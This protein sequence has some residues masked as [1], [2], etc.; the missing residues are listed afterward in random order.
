MLIWTS[1]TAAVAALLWLAT[2][3]ALANIYRCTDEHGSLLFSQYPCPAA[4]VEAMVIQRV[5]VVTT[6]PLTALEMATLKRISQQSERSRADAARDH[7]QARRHSSRKRAE[8][9]ALCARTRTALK[10]LRKRKRGGYSLTKARA[11][12]AD[13]AR[14]RA[15]VSEHC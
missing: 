14:L 2:A 11:L 6:A 15:E 13:E 12:D 9:T 1:P 8:R 4:D 3:P 10:R 7:Q 5:S